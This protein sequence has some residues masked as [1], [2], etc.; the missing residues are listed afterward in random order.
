MDNDPLVNKFKRL[1]EGEHPPLASA[2]NA[3]GHQFSDPIGSVLC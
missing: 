2:V 3:C 1:N